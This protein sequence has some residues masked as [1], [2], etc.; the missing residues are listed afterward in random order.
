MKKSAG[1]S[2]LPS[3]PDWLA[4]ISSGTVCTW[5]FILAVLNSIFAVAGVIG[6]GLLISKGA[7]SVFM[8]LPYTFG[9]LIG[10]TNAWFLFV[11]CKRSIDTEGFGWKTNLAKS[12]FHVA[13]GGK[14]GI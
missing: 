13:T 12:A 14:Y 3:E 5:F 9:I 4:S 7:K 11:M 2:E 1:I 10:L 8:I 6:L